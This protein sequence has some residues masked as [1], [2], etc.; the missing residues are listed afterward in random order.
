M[1][2]VEPMTVEEIRAMVPPLIALTKDISLVE[3]MRASVA[4]RLILAWAE[5]EARARQYEA[6]W[7]TDCKTPD[8]VFPMSR[9]H[10]CP[11]WKPFERWLNE[12]LSEI[13]WPEDMK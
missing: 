11:R 7:R 2:K 4:L 10:D 8:H 13:G 1:S 5:S 9:D 12:V 3:R 6:R